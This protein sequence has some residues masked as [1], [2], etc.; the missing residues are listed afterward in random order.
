MILPNVTIYTTGSMKGFG[1][2]LSF[3]GKNSW[4]H[5]WRFLFQTSGLH[6][7]EFPLRLSLPPDLLGLVEGRVLGLLVLAAAAPI[8]PLERILEG[9]ECNQ[10][11]K[12]ELYLALYN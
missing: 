1:I 5:L 10:D 3:S 7:K 4:E 12:R 6:L 2:R 9:D 8:L 11:R